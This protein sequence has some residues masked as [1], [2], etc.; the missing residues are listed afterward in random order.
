MTNSVTK[1]VGLKRSYI[2]RVG[3]YT[4]FAGAF[5]D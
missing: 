3:D 1:R 2:I 4:V 5:I